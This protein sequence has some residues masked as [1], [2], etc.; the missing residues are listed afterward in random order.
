MFTYMCQFFAK[1]EYIC[2]CDLCFCVLGT[3][4]CDFFE[5]VHKPQKLLVQNLNAMKFVAIDVLLRSSVNCFY[6]VIT[7]KDRAAGHASTSTSCRP[8]TRT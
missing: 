8:A 2:K 1:I 6:G 4:Q 3:L 5:G 7:S